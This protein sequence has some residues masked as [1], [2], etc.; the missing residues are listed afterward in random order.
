MDVRALRSERFGEVRRHG[1]PGLSGHHREDAWALLVP[2]PSRVRAL[3]RRPRLVDVAATACALLG[4]DVAGL[5]GEPLLE[6][7]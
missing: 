1:E 2:G 6:S 7:V 4:G 5:A 3:D